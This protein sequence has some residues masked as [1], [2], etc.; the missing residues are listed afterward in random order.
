MIKRKSVKEK[1][2][3]SLSK[4]FQKFKEGDKV[5][6]VRDQ[7]LNPG[8]PER[9]QGKTGNVIGIRGKGYLIQ[10]NEGN[11]VKSGEQGDLFLLIQIMPHKIFNREGFDVHM[12]LAISFSQAALGA[13]ISIPTLSG[14]E[15]KIKIPK[16]TETGNI[17][18]LKFKEYFNIFKK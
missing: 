17:L 4:Y 1:G 15:I 5:A 3:L 11:A 14:E 16:G 6:I 2:K 13:E 10:L 18:R 9:I 8:F 7:A 12:D